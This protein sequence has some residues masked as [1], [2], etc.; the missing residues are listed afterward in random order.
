MR[1][2]VSRN[3]RLDLRLWQRVSSTIDLFH[4]Q[5]SVLAMNCC[6]FQSH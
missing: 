1:A 5:C 4:I 2:G 6:S 3:K